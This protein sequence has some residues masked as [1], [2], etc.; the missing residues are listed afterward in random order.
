MIKSNVFLALYGVFLCKHFFA[1]VLPNF[2]IGNVNKYI[3]GNLITI[4][5]DR[6]ISNYSRRT[7]MIE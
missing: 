1:G 5:T 2:V 4:N 3:K 6:F 7:M